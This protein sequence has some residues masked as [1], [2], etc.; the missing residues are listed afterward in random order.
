MNL[1]D[2]LWPKKTA[3]DIV[4]AV[5]NESTLMNTSESLPNNMASPYTNG[6]E[7]IVSAITESGTHLFRFK[8]YWIVTLPVVAAT[9]LM[10]IIVGPVFRFSVRHLLSNTAFI[11]PFLML[12]TMAAS[13]AT[14]IGNQFAAY[15]AIV[16]FP[17]GYTAAHL[18]VYASTTGT[19]QLLWCGYTIAYGTSLWIDS[20]VLH[21]RIIDTPKGPFVSGLLPP[22]YLLI[23]HCGISNWIHVGS[24]FKSAAWKWFGVVKGTEGER[25]REYCRGT[26]MLL[27][28]GIAIAYWY[29]V[30]DKGTLLAIPFAILAANRLLS[31]TR[32][33]TRKRFYIWFAFLILWICSVAVDR[34][35]APSKSSGF[36]IAFFPA[37]AL[38]GSWAY[39]DH[40]TRVD[41]V[42]RRYWRR[43]EYREEA[44]PSLERSDSLPAHSRFDFEESSR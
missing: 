25:K 11:V 29:N 17:F 24:R 28:H 20:F 7:A 4:R 43:R 1:Q 3:S 27:Y 38:F 39:S 22:A 44:K 35:L 32:D 37:W 10:P 15:T 2:P 30:R 31:T 9:I 14:S 36:F 33:A 34:N 12:L 6:T 23:T 8:D 26:L 18:M 21:F 16:L 13:L 19:D 40:K 5:S 41:K 42:I